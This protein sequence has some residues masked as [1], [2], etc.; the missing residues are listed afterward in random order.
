MAAFAIA[1]EFAT[2]NIVFTVT[3]GTGFPHVDLVFN[4]LAVAG[5][6]VQRL[7]GSVESKLGLGVVIILPEV[8]AVRVVA[9]CTVVSE[10][11]FML[12]SFLVTGDAVARCV[13]KGS[14]DMT[15]FTGGHCMQT[16]QWETGQVVLE[17]YIN[18]PAALVVAVV[19]IFP[20]LTA[21][22]IIQLV[23]AVTVQRQLLALG[24]AGM[25]F[26][27]SHLDVFVP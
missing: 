3:A 27:A 26:V 13:L 12:V 5:E 21:M 17:S 6:A 19:T 9:V 1:P 8:P 4:R 2:M 14:L 16:D 20:L 7:M 24:G 25:A 23:A 22:S 11:L 10:T 15:T 18:A